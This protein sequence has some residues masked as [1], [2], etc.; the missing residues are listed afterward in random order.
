MDSREIGD[1]FPVEARDISLVQIVHT[2]CGGQ[3]ASYTIGPV[4]FFS[5]GKA[6]GT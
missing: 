2:E 5:E 3:S 4:G 6:D 1:Q